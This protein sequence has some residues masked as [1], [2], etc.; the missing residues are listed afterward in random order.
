MNKELIVKFLPPPLKDYAYFRHATI[1]NVPFIKYIGF[2]LRINK[3]VYW[4]V[5][6]NSEITHPN[7]VFIGINSNIG[8]RPG[9]YIQGNGGVYV[10]NYVI[11][12]S[13]LGII[14]GNHDVY[15][16]TKHINKEVRIGD[17]C[18]LGQGCIILPGVTLGPKTIVGAGAVVTKSFPEGYC[19]IAGNPAKKIRDLDKEKCTPIKH[20]AEYYGYVSKKKFKRFAQRH[21]K[22]NIYCK[23]IIASLDK[24]TD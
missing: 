19:V 3:S 16:H 8:T 14:S 18:W 23:E 13:N 22:N 21:L 1:N 11:S 6:K 2:W 20:K 24:T 7:N 15:D 10:G 12:A 5:N 4:P 17:Y 9:C